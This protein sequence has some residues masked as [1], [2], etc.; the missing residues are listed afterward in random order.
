MV[1]LQRYARLH[2]GRWIQSHS[3]SGWRGG[4]A[5]DLGSSHYYRRA[6]FCPNCDDN[7]DHD[8]RRLQLLSALSLILGCE[9]TFADHIVRF[10]VRLHRV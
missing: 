2:I 8:T 1:E 10:A 3:L 7:R 4:V 6:G 9:L 5:A